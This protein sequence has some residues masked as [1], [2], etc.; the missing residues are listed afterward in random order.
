MGKALVGVA[1]VICVS[2]VL[3]FSYDCLY[4]FLRPQPDFE[5]AAVPDSVVLRSYEESSNATLVTLRSVN[6]FSGEISLKLVKSFG[7][8]GDIRFDL[9]SHSAYLPPDGQYQVTL[10][11]LVVSFV[12][13]GEYYV[14]VVATAGQ[15][16]HTE[17]I[18][19]T[20]SC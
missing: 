1:A 16:E 8:M 9:A 4:G 14:D 15:I 6:G 12:T 10:S 2:V 7:I 18:I 3:Y 5:I 19:I 13:Q 11:L 17:R 20:V